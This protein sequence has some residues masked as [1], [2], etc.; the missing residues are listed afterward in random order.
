[1]TTL[2]E[3]DKPK[4]KYY[5]EKQKEYMRKYREKKG[6]YTEG[7]KKAIYKYNARIREE[8]KKYRELQLSGLITISKY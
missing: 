1:M 7:Q 3:Q 2:V 5:T 8:A 6:S 4:P